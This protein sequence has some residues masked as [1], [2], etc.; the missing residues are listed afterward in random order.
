MSYWSGQ[1]LFVWVRPNR[2]WDLFLCSFTN[3]L[4]CLADCQINE[5]SL[6]KYYLGAFLLFLFLLLFF[7]LLGGGLSFNWGDLLLL[8]WLF[9]LLVHL[10]EK[11][12]SE[13]IVNILGE[14]KVVFLFLF[15]IFFWLYFFFA[16]FYLFHFSRWLFFR[17][18][19]K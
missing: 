4:D 12:L 2:L 9:F 6:S 17:K 15:T 11:D 13:E 8:N 14:F 18:L 19:E 16:L 1:R 7:I 3:L 10:P 5:Y